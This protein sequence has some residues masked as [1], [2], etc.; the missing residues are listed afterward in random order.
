MSN[1]KL[2]QDCLEVLK[3]QKYDEYKEFNFLLAEKAEGF[4]LGNAQGDLNFG[5]GCS[6]EYDEEKERFVLNY[7]LGTF[8]GWTVFDSLPIQFKIIFV[9]TLLST[10]PDG[11]AV[12]PF[13]DV[14]VEEYKNYSNIFNNNSYLHLRQ[15]EEVSTAFES[16]IAKQP[17]TLRQLLLQAFTRVCFDE[18][19]GFDKALEAINLIYLEYAK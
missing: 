2:I 9:Q 7:N 19:Q 11:Q 17:K 4:I 3:E 16:L 13:L 15:F 6:A 12:V 10:A 5:F 14:E 18:G 1:N 8:G